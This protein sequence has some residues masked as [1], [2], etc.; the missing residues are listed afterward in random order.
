MHSIA[1]N[2]AA[3]A[4]EFFIS[5]IPPPFSISARRLLGQDFQAIKQQRDRQ[6]T[7]FEMGDYM[8]WKGGEEKMGAT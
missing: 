5:A 1:L 4:S 2:R 8:T 6:Y 7:M 3:A